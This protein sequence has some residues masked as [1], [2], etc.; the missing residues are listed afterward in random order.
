[1]ADTNQGLNPAPMRSHSLQSRLLCAKCFVEPTIV[2]A[3][4]TD[5]VTLTVSCHGEK[6]TRTIP[7]SDFTFTQRFFEPNEA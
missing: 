3:S 1:M 4:G 7:K 5:V 6:E 2:N